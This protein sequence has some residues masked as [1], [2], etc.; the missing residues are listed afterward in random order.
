[1]KIEQLLRLDL[2]RKRSIDKS[3]AKSMIE[4]SID[5][6]KA[7]KDTPLNEQTATIIFRE[8]YESVRQ[9]GDARLWLLGYEPKNHE[10]SMEILKEIEIKNKIKLNHLMR[11]KNIRNDIN[12]RGF[13]ATLSQANE[14]LEFWNLCCDEIIRNLKSEL[15]FKS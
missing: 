14:I 2:I 6:M 12:Y 4:S 8:T 7:I 9:L 11:F 13:K 15:S 3:L 10:A 1:M 5:V